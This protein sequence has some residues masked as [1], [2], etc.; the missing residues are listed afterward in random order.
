MEYRPYD[1][2]MLFMGVLSTKGFPQSLR[3]SLEEKFG[4]ISVIS[5]SFP[6]SFTDYYVPEMGEGIERFFISF[7]RLVSP[8]SLKEAKRITNEIEKEWEEDG[9]RKIN[10]D[11]GTL[12]EANIILATTKNRAHRIAIG[13]NLYAEVTLIYQNHGYQSFPWTYSDYKSQSVQSILISFR[14]DYLRLR[15]EEKQ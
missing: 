14:K 10:L 3:E 2:V 11:P 4:P 9:K 12:S 13:D 1:S 15:K 7:S 8:S 5:A 6:F